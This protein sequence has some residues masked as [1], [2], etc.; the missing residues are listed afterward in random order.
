MPVAPDLPRLWAGADQL[1]VRL[2]GTAR[3]RLSTY[4]GFLLEKGG[5]TGAT[6]VTDLE[7]VQ[8]RHLLESLAFFAA[9]EKHGL[10]H[11]DYDG[12]IADVGSG[13]GL[14]GIPLAI[15]APRA[16]LTLIEATGRKAGFL[17]SAARLLSLGC[18]VVIADRAETVAH[19]P[20]HREGYDLV[21]S[22]AVAVLPALLEICTP[23]LRPGASM[24][25]IKGSRVDEEL[26]RSERAVRLTNSDPPLV[27]PLRVPGGEDWLSVVFVRKRAPTPPAYPRR[28][29][30]PVKRPL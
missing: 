14:P 5:I 2:D 8:Q 22:R 19:D 29:G 17:R 21:V 18:V 3:Q 10:I 23:L 6:A 24:A 20:E 15:L 27:E 30:I 9:L 7:G 25:A 12:R 1:G 11:P 4:A 26:S 28:P 16:R 13:G